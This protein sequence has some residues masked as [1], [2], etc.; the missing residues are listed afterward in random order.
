[1]AGPS[2]GT[3][4]VIDASG[5]GGTPG[6]TPTTRGMV[7]QAKGVSMK[8]RNRGLQVWLSGETYARATMAGTDM[9]KTVDQFVEW[10]T[11]TAIHL[12]EKQLHAR[13]PGKPFV[14]P[15]PEAS[16][17]SMAGRPSSRHLQNG[18]APQTGSKSAKPG[19]ERPAATRSKASMARTREDPHFDAGE[20]HGT[21]QDMP[22]DDRWGPLP[23]EVTPPTRPKPA[24]R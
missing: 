11:L 15:A 21:A 8:P 24:P 10:A 2:R 20:D 23:G 19:P 4:Q 6:T 18:T 13:Q 7:R 5:R 14:R 1:M 17:L 16:G 12:H 9:G 22:P 3:D